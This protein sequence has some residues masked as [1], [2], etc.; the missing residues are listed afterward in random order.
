MCLQRKNKG[1]LLVL[2]LVLLVLLALLLYLGALGTLGLGAL[3]ALGLCVLCILGLGRSILLAG[4]CQNSSSVL[5]RELYYLQF[6]GRLHY[7]YTRIKT[8]HN[9]L[10][11]KLEGKKGLLTL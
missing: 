11:T 4:Y 7:T 8:R 1:I 9:T 3:G 10:K 5:Y 6:Y 2:V